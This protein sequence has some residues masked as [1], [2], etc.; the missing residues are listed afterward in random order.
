MKFLHRSGIILL[1]T[2]QGASRSLLILFLFTPNLQAIHDTNQ[3]GVSDL[4]EKKFNHGALYPTFTPTADPDGDGWTNAQE[5]AADTDP[6][7]GAGPTGYIRPQITHTPAVYL[8]PATPG[9]P[10]QLLTPEVITVTWPTVAGKKYNL[11]F[12][13]DLAAGSWTAIGSPRIGEGT[14]IGT[15]IPLTQPDGTTPERLFW[16]VTITDVDTDNDTLTD[17]EEAQFGSDPHQP[18]TDGDKLTDSEEYLNNT[19]PNQIDTDQDG[20]PDEWEVTNNLDPNDDGGLDI[21][22][23]P[24]GDPDG[25]EIKNLVDSTPHQADELVAVMEKNFLDFFKDHGVVFR[26]TK[27]H[28]TKLS[29]DRLFVT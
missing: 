26:Y 13:T 16:R 2:V 21:D 20:L 19:D 9:G 17:A 7:S 5:A 4:W 22:N 14:E 3:N 28:T 23:G 27:S 11:L 25:D 8:S 1:P 29:L 15:S 18:D 6:A 24:N 12:S 10:P